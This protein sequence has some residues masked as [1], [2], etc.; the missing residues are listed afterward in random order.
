MLGKDVKR[1]AVFGEGPDRMFNEYLSNA[2]HLFI[3]LG[4]RSG[5]AT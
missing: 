3:E 2:T 5:G 4:D 1:I